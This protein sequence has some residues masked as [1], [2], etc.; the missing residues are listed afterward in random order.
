MTPSSGLHGCQAYVWYIQIYAEIKH[1]IPWDKN[2]IS[3]HQ[4]N[5][6]RWVASCYVPWTMSGISDLFLPNLSRMLSGKWHHYIH[7][8]NKGPRPWFFLAT[9]HIHIAMRVET[10]LIESWFQI[11]AFNYFSKNQDIRESYKHREQKKP[12]LGK[13]QDKHIRPLPNLPQQRDKEGELL[14]SLH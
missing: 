2:S 5:S 4:S 13:L 11:L 10:G 7:S 8:A 14:S 3:A 12:G 9:C 6:S 1:W